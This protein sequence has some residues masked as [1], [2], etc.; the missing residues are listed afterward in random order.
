[1]TALAVQSLLAS[2]EPVRE[3]YIKIQILDEKSIK[4]GLKQISKAILRLNQHHPSEK[5]GREGTHNFVRSLIG[6]DKQSNHAKDDRGE[7]PRPEGSICATVEGKAC[8]ALSFCKDAQVEH[9]VLTLSRDDKYVFESARKWC[10]KN[11]LSH[12]PRDW[13]KAEYVSQSTAT[14][15]RCS[16]GMKVFQAED[17][18]LIVFA[19]DWHVQLAKHMLEA[20][21]ASND[22][23][24]LRRRGAIERKATLLPVRPR[25]GDDWRLGG[26]L[27]YAMAIINHLTTKQQSGRLLRKEDVPFP[28]PINERE[29]DVSRDKVVAFLNS[30]FSEKYARIAIFD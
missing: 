28:L 19:Q 27:T 3:T 21:I 16:S 26:S 10:E 23:V 18:M 29:G 5:I 22:V 2:L 6:I 7:R 12:Y 30:H 15:V 20:Y 9:V 24:S 14:T 1:M 11:S 8:A 13:I 4:Y 17:S 25:A